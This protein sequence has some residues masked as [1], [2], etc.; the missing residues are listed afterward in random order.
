MIKS[1]DFIKQQKISRFLYVTQP[2]LSADI[3]A[4]NLVVELVLISSRK[5]ADKIGGC[6]SLALVKTVIEFVVIYK[7]LV[8]L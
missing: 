4:I 3:L 8:A 1:A 7:L 6:L 5:S 2:I